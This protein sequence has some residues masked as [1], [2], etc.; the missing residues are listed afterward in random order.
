M[1]SDTIWTA[2]FGCCLL[3]TLLLFVLVKQQFKP[4]LC[5]CL[6]VRDL[7]ERKRENG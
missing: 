7:G 3:R 6:N 2:V 4:I 1:I 5:V